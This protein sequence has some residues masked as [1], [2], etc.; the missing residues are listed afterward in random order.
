[1]KEFDNVFPEEIQPESRLQPNK[2]PTQSKT[3]RPFERFTDK[4][5]HRS[6]LLNRLKSRATQ[7]FADTDEKYAQASAKVV[8]APQ[9][10]AAV[11]PSSTPRAAD[12]AMKLRFLRKFTGES[13]RT[14]LANADAD[15]EFVKYQIYQNSYPLRMQ[16]INKVPDGRARVEHIQQYFFD[17]LK[18]NQQQ[19]QALARILRRNFENSSQIVSFQEVE[20]AFKAEDEQKLRKQQISEL[21]RFNTPGIMDPRVQD[22]IVK[23]SMEG[24]I[25]AYLIS[26]HDRLRAVLMQ[27]CNPEGKLKRNQF[28]AAMQEYDRYATEVEIDE[29]MECVDKENTGWISV[30]TFLAWFGQEYCKKRSQRCSAG[31]NPRTWTE[32]YW[33]KEAKMEELRRKKAMPKKMRAPRSTLTTELRYFLAHPKGVVL[34]APPENRPS[35]ANQS[36]RQTT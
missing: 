35:T 17:T 8:A 26:R 4:L 31:I 34:H 28:L 3:W 27:H 22:L 11:K 10:P 5:T 15:E 6:P 12:D 14:P 33:N 2:P 7:T 9:P 36:P 21:H 29:I 30:P 18:L 1:M 24:I 13:G 25:S 32:R 20:S 16:L 19:Q 23:R